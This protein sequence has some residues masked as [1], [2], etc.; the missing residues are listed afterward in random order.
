MI[1][2]NIAI[3]CRLSNMYCIIKSVVKFFLILMHVVLRPVVCRF[4]IFNTAET[5][6]TGQ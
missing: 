6:C 2:E 5:I 4:I 3:E 1:L